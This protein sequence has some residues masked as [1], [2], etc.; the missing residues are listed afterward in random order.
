M[1]EVGRVCVKI[2]GKD[3][4]RIVVVVEKVD[5]NFVLIDGNVKRNRC[6]VRHLEPLGRTVKISKGESS[7]KIKEIL[8]E[9][10]FKVRLVKSK[11]PVE[12]PKKQ[13]K[14]SK[15]KISDLEKKAVKKKVK[16]NE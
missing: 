13:R 9:S 2:A 11:S 14:L 1:Y 8:S 12:K 15:K 7:E 6:N 5:N 16:K 3:A 10:G 4:G